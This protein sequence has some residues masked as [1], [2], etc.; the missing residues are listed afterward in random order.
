MAIRLYKR[1]DLNPVMRST[2]K[3]LRK[4]TKVNIHVQVTDT[5]IQFSGKPFK[6]TGGSHVLCSLTRTGTGELDKDA[7]RK[8]IVGLCD[9]HFAVSAPP[10]PVSSTIDID[11]L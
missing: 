2:L 1:R 3:Q 10:V 9:K 4:N 5:G 8:A 7:V 11:T 6:G